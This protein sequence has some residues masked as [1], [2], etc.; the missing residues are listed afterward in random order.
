MRTYYEILDKIVDII[1]L[2]GNIRAKDM[3]G[4]FDVENFALLRHFPIYKDYVEEFSDLLNIER[5]YYLLNKN[6]DNNVGLK[7]NELLEICKKNIDDEKCLEL[8]EIINRSFNHPARDLYEHNGY[9]VLKEDF[10]RFVE[11]CKELKIG[12]FQSLLE[13]GGELSKKELMNSLE[14]NKEQGLRIREYIEKHLIENLVIS[15]QI[16]FVPQNKLNEV[17]NISLPNETKNEKHSRIMDCEFKELIYLGINNKLTLDMIKTLK[18]ILS[19]KEFEVLEKLL[20]EYNI[21]SE[22]ELFLLKYEKGAKEIN[23]IDELISFLLLQESINI[24]GLSALI[25]FIGNWNY[26][27]MLAQLF[28]FGAINIDDYNKNKT[29]SD[30]ELIH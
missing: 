5:T 13:L 14:N 18:E 20:L 11:L 22:K 10:N 7:N 1:R 3:T 4:K 2:S 24:D 17:I 23:D 15:D 12:P 30:N 27:Y 9:Y 26:H 19:E 6:K 28:K 16:I 21:F 8:F 29:S 25:P